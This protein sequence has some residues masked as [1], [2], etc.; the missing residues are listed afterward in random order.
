MDLIHDNVVTFTGEFFSESY[1]IHPLV[2]PSDYA[3]TVRFTDRR[4]APKQTDW[5]YVR[6]T[7]RNGH[8]AWSSPIWVG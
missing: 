3:M 2:Q 5:Y 7:Q 4:P 8:V 1:I 6:V